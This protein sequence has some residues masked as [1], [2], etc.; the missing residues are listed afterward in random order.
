MKRTFLIL[1]FFL[2]G[3]CCFGQITI[4]EE[5]FNKID[6]AYKN[7]EWEQVLHP[8]CHGSRQHGA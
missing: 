2:C 8:A 7:G 1:T 4:T 6:N 5:Y 3:L